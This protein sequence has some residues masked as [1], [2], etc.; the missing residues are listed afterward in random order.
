[1]K[2]KK[3]RKRN[4]DASSRSD[5]ISLWLRSFNNACKYPKKKKKK[6]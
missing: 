1:M 4:G 5:N 6:F 3:E 2:R